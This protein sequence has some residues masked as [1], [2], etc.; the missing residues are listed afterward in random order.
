M[1][2]G[3]EESQAAHIRFIV[4]DSSSFSKLEGKMVL[5]ILEQKLYQK[6]SGHCP[7]SAI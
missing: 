4:R 3:F 2:Y 1:Y 5:K 7:T 6:E